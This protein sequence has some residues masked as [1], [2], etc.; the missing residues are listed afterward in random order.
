MQKLKL[1]IIT[2]IL[3]TLISSMERIP[4]LPLQTHASSSP[5]RLHYECIEKA[6]SYPDLIARIDQLPQ[7]QKNL[8]KGFVKDETEQWEHAI[9]ASDQSQLNSL[10]HLVSRKLAQSC[11]ANVTI[12]QDD[13]PPTN[14]SFW[15]RC[16]LKPHT[17]THRSFT[18]DL[19]YNIEHAALTTHDMAH[20]KSIHINFKKWKLYF[21]HFA[22]QAESKAKLQSFKA[23]STGTIPALFAGAALY[24][25]MQGNLMP[26]LGFAS[27]E[28]ITGAA[29]CAAAKL[30][31]FG[32]QQAGWI[33]SEITFSKNELD[34]Y[35]TKL[36]ILKRKLL[37][38]AQIK[39]AYAKLPKHQSLPDNLA[40][41]KIEF[42][43]LLETDDITQIKEAVHGT[44][45]AIDAHMAALE[46]SSRRRT[47]ETKNILPNPVRGE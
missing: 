35:V 3:P 19:K 43:K 40:R 7:H 13:C 41:R 14:N 10:F 45:N 8:V 25:L 20:V 2:L 11:P 5:A 31:F 12:F 18:A 28:A 4:L 44:I 23:V 9:N 22:Q 24:T 6:E 36:E 16:C 26:A 46:L 32:N 34:A 21:E 38:S 47:E 30:D 27:V 29:W 37:C 42:N 17:V 1:L 33:E 39:L 15:D